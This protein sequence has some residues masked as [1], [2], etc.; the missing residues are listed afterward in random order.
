L[1]SDNSIISKKSFSQL[2]SYSNLNS[3]DTDLGFNSYTK[4]WDQ[5]YLPADN[6]I[7]GVNAYYIIRDCDA[8]IITFTDTNILHTS[9]ND[10]VAEKDITSI[11]F[12]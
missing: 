2:D 10:G 9:L 11:P 6:F 8:G 12:S 5:N 4:C 3:N 1:T 7:S